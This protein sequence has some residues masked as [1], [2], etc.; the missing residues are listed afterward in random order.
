[1]GRIF[2]PAK[3]ADDW[4]ALLAEPQKQWKSG[5]SAKALAHCWQE[6]DDFPSSVRAAFA[7]S[8]FPLFQ[9]VELLLALPEYKVPL[10]GGRRASQ[11]DLFALG[12]SGDDLVSV[13][14][15]GKVAESFGER[16]EDWIEQRAAEEEKRGRPREPSA[17]A[18]ER[19][20][21]LCEIVG[22]REEEV[23]DLRYQLLHRTA[24]ALIEARR[25]TA[26]HA[27]MLVHSFSQTDPADWL[28]DF[29]TF[30][31]RLKCEEAAGGRVVFVGDRDGIDLYL[32]WAKGEAR[33]LTV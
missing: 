10:P 15:E 2:V 19:L 33:F 17:G 18:Q 8:G 32:G 28:D 12:R 20:K 5:F 13:A 3:S 25:F 16:V 22:L 7:A 11:T 1:V 14:V 6:A 27:L 23:F 24:S 30:A 26:R 21:Y 31:D 29:Q 9:N 4:Q